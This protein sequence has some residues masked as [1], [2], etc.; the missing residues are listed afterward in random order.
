MT[1]PTPAL[2]LSAALRH[3]DEALGDWRFLGTTFNLFDDGDLVFDVPVNQGF[4]FD[5]QTMLDNL[6]KG[7]SQHVPIDGRIQTVM[8]FLRYR[9][10]V[11]HSWM[12]MPE[13]GP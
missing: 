12:Y 6:I 9:G 13:Y 7:V 10:S 5:E 2:D 3:L 1:E 4:S 11:A 8:V